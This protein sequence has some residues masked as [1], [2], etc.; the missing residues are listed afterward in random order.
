MKYCSNCGNQIKEG[1]KFCNECGTNTTNEATP[2]HQ[3]GSSSGEQIINLSAINMDKEKIS[4]MTHGYF[5]YLK[6]TLIKPSESLNEGSSANGVIQF[7][8][9]SLIQVLSV[10]FLSMDSYSYSYVSI[11]FKMLLG[12]FILL[13]IFNFL[14][15][16]VVHGVKKIAYRS[17][18]S[19]YTTTTQYGGFFS[20]SVLLHTMVM[21]LALI[22]GTEFADFMGVLYILSF[23]ISF[24]AFANYLYKCDGKPKMDKFYVGVIATL[25]LFLVW[26]IV[27]RIG[28][29]TVLLVMEDIIMDS[30]F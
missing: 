1:A 2:N 3:N 18:D 30:M 25:V 14:S 20:S 17:E 28:A 11:G 16:F 5:S 27:I 24:F 8:L 12:I 21:L 22:T 19:F 23:I 10:W 6:N 9:L 4:T 7:I 29:E 15:A 26:F 13:T